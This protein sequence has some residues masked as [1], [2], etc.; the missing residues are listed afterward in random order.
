M[1]Y[2]QEQAAKLNVHS[3][4]LLAAFRQAEQDYRRGETVYRVRDKTYQV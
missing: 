2:R 3:E 4:G 1:N